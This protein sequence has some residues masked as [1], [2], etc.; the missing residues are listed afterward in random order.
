MAEPAEQTEI[1][2]PQTLGSMI[3]E[4]YRLRE[5]KRKLDNASSDI[6]KSMDVLDEKIQG[7]LEAQGTTMSRGYEASASITEQDIFV[8]EDMDE[9]GRHIIENDALHLLERRPSM[10]ACRELDQAGES[11]PGLKKITRKKISLRKV[12]K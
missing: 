8:I 7:A 4:M 2:Q 6:K 1:E 12:A 3:D 5:D 11:I 10:G 9:Y